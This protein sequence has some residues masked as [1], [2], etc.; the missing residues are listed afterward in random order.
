MRNAQNII[1]MKK[2]SKRLDIALR[3]IKKGDYA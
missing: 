1:D 2:T 3:S